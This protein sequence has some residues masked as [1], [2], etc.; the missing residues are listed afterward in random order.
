M[1][2]HGSTTMYLKTD[3][4]REDEAGLSWAAVQVL[5]VVQER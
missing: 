1:A 4:S 3:S 2:L 5:Y